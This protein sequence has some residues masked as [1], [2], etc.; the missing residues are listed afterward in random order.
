M[1]FSSPAKNSL[2]ESE[3]TGLPLFCTWKAVY[4]FVLGTFALW[5]AL[6]IA[7]TEMFS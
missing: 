4:I 3:E 2:P 5:L 7:L 6:L 1:K